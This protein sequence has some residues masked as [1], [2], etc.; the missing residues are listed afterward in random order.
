MGA[1]AAAGDGRGHIT[2][3]WQ[4]QPFPGNGDASSRVTDTPDPINSAD[5]GKLKTG[6][7]IKSCYGFQ[8]ALLQ[9]CWG[10]GMA[11]EAASGLLPSC[12]WHARVSG[13]A[14]YQTS[15]PTS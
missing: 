1:Q 15:T 5:L 9:E 7:Q 10:R 2:Q 14:G 13:C 11:G 12:L 4:D 6:L 8:K 3:D